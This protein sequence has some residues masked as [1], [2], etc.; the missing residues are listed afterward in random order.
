MS[1]TVHKI[2]E[3]N[4]YLDGNTHAGRVSECKMPTIE[5]E[6]QEHDAL[7]MSFT[8]SLPAK[9]KEMEVEMTWNAVYREAENKILNPFKGVALQ[10]RSNVRVY[11]AGGLVDELPLVTFMTVQFY[12]NDMGSL[13]MKDALN[14]PVKGKVLS[15]RQ[16]LDGR[17]TLFADPWNNVFRVNGEDILAK[18][19]K[20]IGA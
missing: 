1:I 5:N 14:R 10:L 4:A 9:F 16:V 6:M 7:G 3:A 15:F 17:E 13:N 18:M 8:V 2:T 11:N 19:R 12:S 20:N